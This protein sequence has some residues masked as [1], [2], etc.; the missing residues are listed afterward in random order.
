MTTAQT[1][2]LVVLGDSL[3]LF[4]PR[5]PL[6]PSA[7]ALYP[8]RTR[9][10]LEQATGRPW[11]LK[12]IARG[13]W[14]LLRASR[15]VSR[16][17]SMRQDLRGASAILIAL[18]S[19]DSMAVA[20][21]HGW[22]LFTREPSPGVIPH[23]SLSSRRRLWNVWQLAH[24]L[25]IRLTGARFQ[26]TPPSLLDRSWREFMSYVQ[27]LAPSAALCGMLPTLHEY[28]VF[29]RSMKYYSSTAS[30]LREL[31]L[32][33]DI[34]MI[35]PAPF[36]SERLGSLPDGIHWDE[37]LHAAAAHEFAEALLERLFHADVEGSALQANEDHA[38]GEQTFDD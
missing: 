13:G 25:G 8:D 31:G 10:L 5:G 38:V 2:R 36:V 7:E 12:V 16:D 4:G 24:R 19:T 37:A 28:P 6:D 33:F 9:R 32:E 23:L 20:L 11:R 29:A 22:G 26:H 18:A 15:S 17:H 30:Q 35:D 3:A 27:Q 34:P 1:P 21:P 14:S